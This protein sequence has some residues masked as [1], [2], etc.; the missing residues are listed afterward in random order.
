MAV[1]IDRRL[2]ADPSTIRLPRATVD[3]LQTLHTDRVKPETAKITYSLDRRTAVF[4]EVGGQLRKSVVV[5]GVEVPRK[6][7]RR[8]D[9]VTLVEQGTTA[10]AQIEIEQTIE[11]ETTVFDSATLEVKK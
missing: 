4:F 7:A 5:E 6:P 9:T 2:V 1:I 10:M 3:L 8:K 11:A